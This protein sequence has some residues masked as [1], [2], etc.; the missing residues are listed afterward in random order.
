MIRQRVIILGFDSQV[1]KFHR[2]R[3]K[4]LKLKVIEH[5]RSGRLQYAIRRGDDYRK[6]GRGRLLVMIESADITPPGMDVD[7]RNH[8]RTDDHPDNLRLRDSGENR[9]D[10]WSKAQYDEVADFFDRVG[11]GTRDLTE[12]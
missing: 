11:F 1:Y 6:I 10:N 3:M 9:A 8:D 2:S 5:S 12:V 7:H 4:Y